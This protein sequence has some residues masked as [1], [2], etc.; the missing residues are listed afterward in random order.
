MW[1]VRGHSGGVFLCGM[2]L[3]TA[4]AVRA[5]DLQISP[6]SWDFGNVPVGSS[7]TVPFD[8]LAGLPTEVWVYVIGFTETATIPTSGLPFANPYYGVWSLGLS[9]SIPRRI[10]SSPW[11]CGWTTISMST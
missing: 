11:H 8:L 2:I 10:R 9:R 1:N 5:Q 6:M 4:A 7:G 3:C